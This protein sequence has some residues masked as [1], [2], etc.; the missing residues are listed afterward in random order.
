M[1]RIIIQVLA[2][3]IAPI[4]IYWLWEYFTAKRKNTGVR[5]WEEGHWFYAT[6]LGFALAFAS[7]GYFAWTGLESDQ[8]RPPPTHDVGPIESDRFR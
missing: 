1:G 6:L 5:G 7:F 2:P 4:L 3:L 8:G